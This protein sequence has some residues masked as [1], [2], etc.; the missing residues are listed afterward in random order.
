MHSTPWRNHLNGEEVL[1]AADQATAAATITFAINHLPLGIGAYYSRVRALLPS[2]PEVI[3]TAE[4]P[5]RPAD[6]PLK[7]LTM[8][9]VDQLLAGDPYDQ[10]EAHPAAADFPGTVPEGTPLTEVR[11]ALDACYEGALGGYNFGGAGQP[12]RLATGAYALPGQTFTVTVPERAVGEGLSVGRTHSDR[13]WNK[14]SIERFPQ[15]IRRYP[16]NAEEVRAM[17]APSVV[18]STWCPPGPRSS[19]SSCVAQVVKAPYYR[20]VDRCPF[21]G[22]GT[23]NTRH[24]G[25]ERGRPRRLLCAHRGDA[26]ARGPCGVDDLLGRGARRRL[27]RFDENGLLA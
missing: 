17:T 24:P 19:A 20:R 15:I 13:L 18:R 23:A 11:V 6:E 4:N 5:V 2:L 22:T 10:I 12:I 7:M 26:L 9:P 8:R 14:E 21:R 1:S 25:P 27:V 16:V 3:P